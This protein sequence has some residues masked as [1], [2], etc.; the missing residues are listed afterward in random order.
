LTRPFNTNQ[1]ASGKKESKLGATPR[2]IQVSYD[3]GND[4]FR[5]WLDREMSYTCAMFQGEESLEDA[6]VRKLAFLHDAAGVKP[7]DSVLDIGCGWGANLEYLASRGVREAHGITLSPAQ[8]E[9][10]RRRD[11]PS[12][13]AECV[14]YADYQPARPF[15]AVIS[16][17]ML[18]HVVSPEQAKA[19]EAVERYRDYFRRVRSFCRPRARFALQTI[20]RDLPPVDPSD[21][22]EI[23][24]TTRT[25][26]PGSLAPRLEDLVVAVAPHWE[27]LE[28]KTSREDYRR[29]CEAWRLRLRAHE[30][31][32]RSQFGD[33]LFKV[34]D[35]YL[36]ASVLAFAKHYLSLCR[37]SLARID[38]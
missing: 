35:R 9:E 25:I 11:R 26:F 36:S 28:L 29:T 20:V 6:Q 5:L 21:L 34:Y 10:I 16:I 37:F 15:D 32:V 13:S 19:G 2:D 3:V 14:S 33:E 23:G 7:G 24:W 31:T 17:G 4:F 8:I 1:T 22:R 38:D 18:E 27:I 12:V 30:A